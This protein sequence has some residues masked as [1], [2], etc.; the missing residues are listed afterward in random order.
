MTTDFQQKKREILS[1][2]DQDVYESIIEASKALDSL[3]LEELLKHKIVLEDIPEE[4][5]YVPVEAIKELLGSGVVEGSSDV[6]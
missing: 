1:E 6:T 5:A 3:Y 2:L 4:V